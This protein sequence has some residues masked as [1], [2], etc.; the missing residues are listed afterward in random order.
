MDRKY[1]NEGFANLKLKT[2]EFKRFRNFAKK[3]GQSNSMTL[4]LMLDFFERFKI[5]PEE[6]IGNNMMTLEKRIGKRIN[7]LIAILKSIERDQTLP[8]FAILKSFLEGFEE[9]GEPPRFVEKKHKRLSLE[10]EL[11]KLKKLRQ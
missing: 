6:D 4:G 9:E 3:M 5:S 8:T 11:E 2:S 1:K 10:E 7:T